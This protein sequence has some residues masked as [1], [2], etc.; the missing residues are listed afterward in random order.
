MLKPWKWKEAVER[1]ALDGEP[2]LEA[3]RQKLLNSGEQ[4]RALG[5]TLDAV[6]G[7]HGKRAHRLGALLVQYAGMKV[8]I[9]P[10]R[11]L[12]STGHIAI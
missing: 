12:F 5:D 6:F 1:L 9:S 3:F 2:G 4:G 7:V 8:N 10:T 11:F